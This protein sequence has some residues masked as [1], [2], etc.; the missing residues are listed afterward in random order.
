[1][2]TSTVSLE[3]GGLGRLAT[4]V[5]AGRAILVLVTLFLLMDIVGK[6]LLLPPVVETMGTLG[7]SAELSRAIGLI[8]LGCVALFLVPR[9][10]VL[11]AVLL[12]AFLGGAVATHLR[13]GNPL[14]S[15]VM[16]P[17]Y[18]GILAWTSVY[19]LDGRVRRLLGPAKID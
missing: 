12:T 16:T 7:Y 11:G 4:R 3:R 14:L 10:R 13:V 5:V 19:L 6:I 1:M 2:T 8:L 17:V 18:A 15:H 9:T